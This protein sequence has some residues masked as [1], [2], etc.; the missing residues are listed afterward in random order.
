M[1][2]LALLA[3]GFLQPSNLPGC[4][5]NPRPSCSMP[6]V[7]SLEWRESD[8]RYTWPLENSDP[9]FSRITYHQQPGVYG[10][11][12]R[13]RFGS[14][15]YC[16]ID[17]ETNTADCWVDWEYQTVVMCTVD[18]WAW[19]AR[20]TIPYLPILLYEHPEKYFEHRGR[21]QVYMWEWVDRVNYLPTIGALGTPP[22]RVSVQV[23]R[24][25]V[26]RTGPTVFFY[27]PAVLMIREQGSTTFQGSFDYNSG[28]SGAVPTTET[29]KNACSGDYIFQ[30][31]WCDFAPFRPECSPAGEEP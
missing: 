8:R 11:I 18:R 27:A 31:N 14:R 7:P 12:E 23:D 16:L 13:P 1:S 26:I 20:A 17:E 29:E 22:A 19:M 10:L 4:N 24:T 21:V 9:R 28:W 30:T 5:T 3:L 2:I 25:Q 15:E 6:D